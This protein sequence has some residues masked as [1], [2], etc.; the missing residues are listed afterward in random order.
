MS[1]DRRAPRPRA[2]IA[3]RSRFLLLEQTRNAQR[4]R[5]GREDQMV[6]KWGPAS[7]H[8]AVLHR[9]RRG[10]WAKASGGRA[11][12]VGRASVRR[13]SGE[14]RG[15]VRA[16]LERGTVPGSPAVLSYVNSSATSPDRVISP[17]ACLC[18]T[19]FTA[20]AFDLEPVEGSFV[21]KPGQLK[22]LILFVVVVFAAVTLAG[23][24]WDDGAA[25]SAAVLH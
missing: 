23:W 2:E 3:L 21:M 16:P 5:R 14:G 22:P 8:R 6:P 13:P 18:D 17:G 24:T 20:H 12:H 4:C 11:P 7:R 15:K 10:D 19:G 1:H 9:A 25:M